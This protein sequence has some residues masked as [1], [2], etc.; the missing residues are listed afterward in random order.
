VEILA[1][2]LVSAVLAGPTSTVVSPSG[3]TGNPR[4]VLS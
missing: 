4:K 1:E 2:M 3:N